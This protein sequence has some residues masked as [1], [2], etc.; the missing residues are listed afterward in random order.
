MIVVGYL[1]KNLTTIILRVKNVFN[2]G[3]G[4][5]YYLEFH[6]GMKVVTYEVTIEVI[7]S[8]TWF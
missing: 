1:K 8:C 4:R 6:D 7:T 5:V 3:Y 2:L